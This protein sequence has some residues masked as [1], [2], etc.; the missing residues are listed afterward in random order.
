MVTIL[1]ECVCLPQWSVRNSDKICTLCVLCQSIDLLLY[2]RSVCLCVC[3]SLFICLRSVYV[4][5]DDN[6]N[7]SFNIESTIVYT[8]SVLLSSNFIACCKQYVL[9]FYN[10]PKLNW[11]KDMAEMKGNSGLAI[12]ATDFPSSVHLCSFL[13]VIFLL[14]FSIHCTFHT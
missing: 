10:H 13:I 7:S 1:L 8:S 11:T 2:D 12:W 6:I 4:H 9:R 14:L 3:F 5:F